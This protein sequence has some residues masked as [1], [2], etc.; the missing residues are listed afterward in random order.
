MTGGGEERKRRGKREKEKKKEDGEGGEG[1]E[2]EEGTA[3]G[4]RDEK[5]TEIKQT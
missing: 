3:E 4:E 5:R 1:G 2:K